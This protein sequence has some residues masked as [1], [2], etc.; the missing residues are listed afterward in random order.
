MRLLHKTCS[1]MGG[2]GDWDHRMASQEPAQSQ[3]QKYRLVFC[4][5]TRVCHCYKSPCVWCVL[6]SHLDRMADTE[7]WYKF[8]KVPRDLK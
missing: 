2:G 5:L 8:Q 4:V 6:V 3:S 7:P 1:V